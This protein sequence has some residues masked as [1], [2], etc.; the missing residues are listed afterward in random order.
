M[1]FFRERVDAEPWADVRGLPLGGDP[2]FTFKPVK[3]G[4]ER[5]RI[6]FQ[7]FARIRA[8]G[9]AERVTV[10]RSPEQGLQ[11]EHVQ[12]A[13]QDFRPALIAILGVAHSGY[14]GSLPSRM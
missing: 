1:A 11:D 8:D 9:F 4:V 3:G 10:T 2:A 12:S 7:D 6:Y 14:V 13:L 5:A